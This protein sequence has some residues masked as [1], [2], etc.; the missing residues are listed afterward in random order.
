ELPPGVLVTGKIVE[1][2]SGQPV[3]GAAVR[4]AAQRLNPF[5]NGIPLLGVDQPIDIADAQGHF[6]IAIPAGRGTLTVKSATGEHV[7]EQ[8]DP[9]VAP[10]PYG[11]RLYVNA[12]AELDLAADARQHWLD[13]ALTA[14]VTVKGQVVLGDGSEPKQVVWVHRGLSGPYSDE[15]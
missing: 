13:L 2:G 3:A 12:H 9:D 11:R 7:L 6:A 8:L 14:G 10:N 5:A 1:Q 15:F 4:Y